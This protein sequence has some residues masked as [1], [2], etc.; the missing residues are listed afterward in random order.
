MAGRGVLPVAPRLGVAR[1]WRAAG[2]PAVAAL[3]ALPRIEDAAKPIF[4]VAVG[5]VESCSRPSSTRGAS[6][7]K[8]WPT[9]KASAGYS[10][11][12]HGGETM[13]T[14]IAS[15]SF[16][17]VFA[18]LVASATP[19]DAKVLGE[20]TG[21]PVEVTADVAK[22]SKPRADINQ[23]VDGRPLKPFQGLTS[24]AAFQTAGKDTFV[25]GDLVLLEHEVNP[26]LSAALSN[27]LEV[28]ALHN[29][30]FYDNPNVYFMH[31]AGSGTLETLG[32][33]VKKT[34]DAAA[35]A[36]KAESLPGGTPPPTDS[37]DAAPLEMIF[38]ASSQAKDGMV[39]FV[40]GRTT[41]MHGAMMG[42]TMGVNTWAVFAGAPD[43]ALVDGDFAM[44]ES[45]LQGVL[46]ALRAASINVVAIHNHMT[47]EEPRIIFLHY[48]GKG[49]AEALAR[50]VQ[51]AR[52]TQ[53]GS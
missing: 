29:H 2:V 36:P 40:F 30:F 38:G 45:E 26:T 24:W 16:A 49:T 10:D 41:K 42:A 5:V 51:A 23:V 6:S 20:L 9:G 32:L 27:G 34:L 50:G 44:L 13:R 48:W 3:I 28:T 43:A 46:K 14:V 39:K 4:I 17:I 8:V 22:V 53:G 33:A 37:I 12:R 35:A 21:L 7:D 52:L 25:M 47:H 18:P 1:S 19:P 31:I 11:Q 15:L